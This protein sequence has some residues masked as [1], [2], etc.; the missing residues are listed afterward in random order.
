A[1]GVEKSP[2]HHLHI[3]LIQHARDNGWQSIPGWRRRFLG[4]ATERPVLLRNSANMAR[5]YEV[6][7]V[8]YMSSVE[9]MLYKFVDGFRQYATLN[10]D[11][12]W[13]CVVLP[14]FP[15]QAPLDFTV[16]S[17]FP[18]AAPGAGAAG[19]PPANSTAT[20]SPPSLIP[21][22]A[23]AFTPTTNADAAMADRITA[24]TDR[25]SAGAAGI[26]AS[27]EGMMHRLKNIVASFHDHT[28]L[29]ICAR[30]EAILTNPAFRDEDAAEIF[31]EKSEVKVVKFQAYC[32]LQLANSLEVKLALL[33]S[34]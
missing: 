21:T 13:Y 15:N 7:P 4:E 11:A 25:I 5:V 8:L 28:K 12:A 19:P 2:G 32:E 33:L 9:T 31:V 30:L 16:Q 17:I 23:G 24:A 14:A 27:F 10:P 3:L 6:H 1:A 22:T 34:M 26:T 29:A 18:A 20:I